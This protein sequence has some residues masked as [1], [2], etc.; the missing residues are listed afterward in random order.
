MGVPDRQAKTGDG[1]IGAID[2]IARRGAT[3]ARVVAAFDLETGDR[4][5]SGS[6]G[7]GRKGGSAGAQRE[8]SQRRRDVPVD[9]GTKAFWIPV[10]GRLRTAFRPQVRR[11]DPVVGGGLSRDERDG[12][13]ANP[14][15]AGVG[16]GGD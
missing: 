8:N 6:H 12:G 10:G 15:A 11:S 16:A 14:N 9:R 13:L 1:A 4:C 5:Y 7:I 2:S 3:I